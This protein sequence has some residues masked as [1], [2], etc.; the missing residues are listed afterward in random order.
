MPIKN[1]QA[2][3]I[4]KYVGS[5]YIDNTQREEAKLDAYFVNNLS[6][7]YEWNPK[8]TFKS[9]L[10]SVIG[11]NILNAKYIPYGSNKYGESYIP[12]AEAHYLAGITLSF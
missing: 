7:Q 3:L 6:L 10:F 8:H 9:V 5:Q 2:S 4:S 11:N 12:A 1:F